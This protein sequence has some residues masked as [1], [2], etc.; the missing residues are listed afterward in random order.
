MSFDGLSEF[1][2]GPLSRLKK[3]FESPLALHCALASDTD[4]EQLVEQLLTE[5]EVA[6]FGP[7]CVQQLRLWRSSNRLQV[8]AARNLQLL[9]CNESSPEAAFTRSREVHEEFEEIVKNDPK[10]FLEVAVKAA[11][12]VRDSG[13]A[14]TRAAHEDSQR[15]KYC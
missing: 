5:T 15:A 4:V 14:E 10:Y 9:A 8:R 11:K 13:T 2:P 6:R 7:R 1:P 12:R 3:A